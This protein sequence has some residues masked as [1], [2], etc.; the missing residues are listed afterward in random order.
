VPSC[1]Y[2]LTGV[3]CVSRVYTDCGVFAVGPDGVRVLDPYGATSAELLAALAPES[4]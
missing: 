1:T 3:G 2:P 4:T